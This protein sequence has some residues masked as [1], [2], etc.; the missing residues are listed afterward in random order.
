M[1]AKISGRATGAKRTTTETGAKES[2]K[3]DRGMD[4]RFGEGGRERETV[5]RV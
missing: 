1:C 5:G 3:V 2:G 4:D